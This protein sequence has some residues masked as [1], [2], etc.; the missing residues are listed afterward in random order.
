MDHLEPLQIEGGKQ[1]RQLEEVTGNGTEEK[2][3]ESAS[4]NMASHPSMKVGSWVTQ[5]R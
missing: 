3:E 5:D 1:G 4:L 2:E